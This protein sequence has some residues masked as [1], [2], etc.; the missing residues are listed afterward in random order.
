MNITLHGFRR[1]RST[2]AIWALEEVGAEYDYV[3]VDFAS[4]GHLTDS[5][6]AINPGR[7]VPTLVCDDL[8]LTESG[9]IV[10]WIGERFPD[11]G[12]LPTAG[13]RERALYDQW[14]LFVLTELEQPLWTIGKHRFALPKDWRVP[15]I[16][17]TAAKEWGRAAKVL[18]DGLGERPWILGDHFTL[19]D[20]MVAHTL[21]WATAFKLPPEH[22]NL[23]AYAK[24]ALGRPAL[25]RAHAREAA[26]S[27]T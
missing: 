13:S 23:Q 9:A 20:I 11:A 4:G 22:A 17:D 19:A 16:I 5:F 8:A 12:H 7:K 14:C 27:H 15:A 10:T 6:G 26:A 24:R 1:S 25:A 3:H 2:R 18:S 21:A